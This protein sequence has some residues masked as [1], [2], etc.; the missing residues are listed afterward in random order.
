M[1]TEVRPKPEG[2]ARPT[3]FSGYR[4]G[5]MRGGVGRARP[6]GFGRTSVRMSGGRV[7]GVRAG[8]SGSFGRGHSG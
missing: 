4:M 7:T 1:R 6:S 5:A 3:A 2:R 8:G